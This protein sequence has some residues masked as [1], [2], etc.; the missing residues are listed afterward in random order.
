M[1]KLLLLLNLFIV[2]TLVSA[3][4]PYE[5]DWI[6]YNQEYY[7]VKVAQDGIYRLSFNTLTQAGFAVS[8]LDPRKIQLFHNG[9]EVPIY[10]EGESDGTFD[11]A[12]FIEF[13][14]RK[15]DGSLDT[16]LYSDPNHQPAIEYSIAN[17]TS[18]YFLT[19]NPIGN[20]LRFTNVSD[21]NYSSYTPANYFIRE[22]YKGG[23]DV[24]NSSYLFGY[25]RGRNEQS[26]EYTESEG[27]GAVF[28]NFSAGNYPITVPMPTAN[29][30]TAGPDI[31]VRTTVGGVNNLEHN[32][33]ITYQGN[34]YSDTTYYAQTLR[35]LYFTH[36]SS[37]FTSSVTNFTFNVST[38]PATQTDYSM[39][40]SL[41]VKYPH[42]FDLEG[43]TSFKLLVPDASGQSMTRADISNFNGS[44]APILYDLTNNRR[45]LVSQ[46]GAAYQTLIPNNGSSTPKLCY[47]ANPSVI[48]NPSV[49]KIAYVQNNLGYFTDFNSL[50]V[51]S[52][53]LIVTNKGLW[54][55]AKTYEAR[56]DLTENNH[57]L[58]I[59]VAEL[60]DQFAYGI[61]NHPLG[62]KNFSRW[63]LDTWTVAPPTHMFILGKS[64]S[65]A[66]FRMDPAQ[67]NQCL[68]ASYGVPPSDNLFTSG[69]NGSMWAPKIPIGRLSATNGNEILDY[70]E[71]VIEYEDVQAG[72][73]QPWMK[74]ILHFGG[75]NDVNQQN[76]LAGYLSAFESI[77]E[78][79]LY[80]GRVTTY[81]KYSNDPI[82]Y[83][84]SDSLQNQID[85][86]V[87]L[88]TFFGHASGSGFD[89]STD[90]PSA[91]GNRGRY[92][93][94]VANACFAGDFHTY[95]KSVSEQFVL[96]PQ[97]AAIGFLASVGQGIP[98]YLYDYSRSLFENAS[99]YH[100]GASIGQLMREAVLN[101]EPFADEGHKIVCNEM[102]FQGDPSLKLNSFSLPD[103]A[104]TEP[105]ITYLPLQITTDIDSFNISV[106][107]RNYG[108][109][110]QDSIT[111]KVIRTFPDNV[112]SVYNFKIGNCYY[113]NTLAFNVATGGFAAAG[114]NR[115]SVEIDLPD[116]VNEVDNFMN[117]TANTQFFITSKDI[118]PV[119][120][121]KYAIHPFNTV[122]LKGSTSNPFAPVTAYRFEIDTID[123][124][125]KDATPGAQPSPLFRFTTVSDSGG[126]ISWSPQGYTLLDSVVYFWRVANDSIQYDP[127]NFSWQQSSFQY[128]NG[129]SGWAQSHFYQFK[130][131]QFTNV[132]FDTV[133]R[134][135]D[136]V[137]N[138]Y[139]LRIT[140]IGQPNATN[141]QA[142]GYYFNNTPMEYNGCQV[143]PAVMVAVLDSI[144]LQPWTT[145]D[146]N[147][148]QANT[149]II[150]PT[151]PPCG[152]LTTRGTIPG[153][154][155]TRPENYFIFRYSSP[156]QMQ[157]LQDLINS[158]P[159]GNYI[160]LYSW[161]T[162]AYS[163]LDPLFYSTL[164]SLGF[165]TGNLGDNTPYAYFL[166]QGNPLIKMEQHSGNLT[167][168]LNLIT[169]INSLWNKGS[170]TSTTLGPSSN[171]ESLHWN[172]RPK[173]SQP[174][175]DQVSVSIYGL[176]ANLNTWDL[177]QSGIQYQSGKDTTL[178]WINATTYPYIRLETL[179][180]DD[181]LKTPPQMTYWRVYHTEVPECALN[182][183]YVYDFHSKVLT[184]GDTLR[185][186]IG[187][188]NL[189]NL[190][191]DSLPVQFYMYDANRTQ[192]P[193][194][195]VTLDSL[196]ANQ[197]LVANISI[198]NTFGY[199]GINSLWID[200]NPFG[201]Q[202]LPEKY[203]FNNVAEIKYNVQRDNINPILDVTFD[204]IHILNGDIVSG[205][206][207]ITI[208][209]NDENKFLALDDSSH[210]TVTLTTPTS[211]TPIVLNYLVQTYGDILHFTPAMLPKNS[212]RLNWNPT[213]SDD[214]IYTI[215]VSAADKSNNESGKYHYK[216]Q[217]EVVNKSS[218]T[219]VLNYP[220]PFST[221][222]RFVFTLTGN[223]TPTNM[224][225][226][227]MT[228]SGK[229]VRE[230]MLNELGNIHV[231]RNITDYAWDGK[232]EFGDQ[233]AN[234]LYLY[235][236]VTDLNGQKIEKRETEADKYFK[237]GWGKMY[238]MR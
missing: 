205:K 192:H 203:H 183:N 16:R 40:Y 79:S 162:G 150:D 71:K 109:A 15:N 19:Y 52:A 12:D 9:Q 66:D 112:D 170:I 56:R 72:P 222:T 232:D 93:I 126:V 227:I 103:Y 177:L 73:P 142:V 231:G 202:H 111:V 84:L 145:C 213:L 43:T 20:G 26:I 67:Q 168:T 188:E 49:S 62:I 107:T 165:N 175:A 11:G 10:L 36:P 4:G 128:I 57:A 182:P 155:R 119:Y 120:P 226:Q 152:Y 185:L 123:L 221:S 184:E 163:S 59:D 211:S 169:Q 13:F 219:E 134:D 122:T 64:I 229:I 129:K 30:Y 83:N 125:H 136:Y 223:E 135:F 14:G 92:P 38:T 130:E 28:G 230:I 194:A 154:N 63:L 208:Q 25:N 200:V 108:K 179:T 53:F 199:P 146:H 105:K 110:I 86:G 167:D 207:E 209:L 29:I 87:S 187:I 160:L 180:Q 60:Y 99:Y 173:E 121:P 104:I 100:Y 190:S 70:L 6:K 48:Q 91:Y 45:I 51:D 196:R 85:S 158:V 68:V 54:N 3:Q 47:I 17:D 195:T 141:F 131:D 117:N 2:S 106:T 220:N 18:V 21:N 89:A 32:L 214:G 224:K 1:K 75:G 191:M 138:N 176:N 212:C 114:L 140:T 58:L 50:A 157:G 7:K 74:E 133:D 198:D 174:Y 215:D 156:T 148:G 8:S 218:I 147:Y 153:C 233:L 88:M 234:G 46:S 113:S 95:R 132:V 238:L 210:F 237:K 204:G 171:W 23:I 172:Q 181:S 235:R 115:I 161:F 159:T 76:Q 35:R 55:Q 189:S 80:G 34:S 94:M 236:V 24:P 96:E 193:L 116:S 31:E 186:S 61:N 127:I 37:T 81:L 216:I 41:Y 164:T 102:S 118:V 124:N 44:T 82:Q 228:V 201:S 206:P 225:I 97:K 166:Q 77:M 98:N 149:F 90:V 65:A 78:D 33:T 137:F 197:R 69:I 143:D 151:G 42:T 217:F 139:S 22:V 101:L 178:S 39:I 5:N 27:W 144:S